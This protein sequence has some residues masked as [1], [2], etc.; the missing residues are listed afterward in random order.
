MKKYYFRYFMLA[1]LC[2]VVAFPGVMMAQRGE[3]SIQQAGGSNFDIAFNHVALSVMDVDRSARF[4]RDVLRLDEIINRTEVAGI[5]WFSL[6]NGHELHLIS[7]LQEE[8]RINKAVHFALSTDQFDAFMERLDAFGI[9]YSDWPGKQ[10]RVNVRADGIRQVFF[11]D[12]DGYW[13]EMNSVLTE[14]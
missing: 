11:Q 10:G 8:V 7:I 4:Y 9:K 6:G 14:N 13:L 12:P 1:L 2:G 3:P 5:R